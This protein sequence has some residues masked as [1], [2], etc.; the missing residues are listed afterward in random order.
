MRERESVCEVLADSPYSWVRDLG[1]FIEFAAECLERLVFMD[2][3]GTSA[4]DLRDGGYRSQR[5][6]VF[7][8]PE[9]K[10]STGP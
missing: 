3:L 1:N 5:G 10:P 2:L 7:A 6:F 9:E 8:T 4:L